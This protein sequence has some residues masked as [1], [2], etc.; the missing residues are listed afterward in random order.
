M[1]SPHIIRYRTSFLAPAPAGGESICIVME[2]ADGGTLADLIH[3]HQQRRIGVPEE[4]VWRCL[5]QVRTG[6]I[7][8]SPGR[9]G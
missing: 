5:V 6:R 1:Q 4:T 8:D 7:P 2:Y 9:A 3:R